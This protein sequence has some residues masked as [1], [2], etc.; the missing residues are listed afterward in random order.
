MNRLPY[1][2]YL[3]LPAPLQLADTGEWSLEVYVGK[4]RG[5]KYVEKKFSAANIFETKEEAINHCVKLGKRIIDGKSE[6]CTVDDL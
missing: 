3:I 4:E 5:S 1:K 2:G 6:K